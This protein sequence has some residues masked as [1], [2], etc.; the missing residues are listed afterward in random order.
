MQPSFEVINILTF[1]AA[2]FLLKKELEYFSKVLENP[3]KPLLV[4]MGG[5][6]VKDKIKIISNMLDRVNRMIITGGMAYT[7]LRVHKNIKIGNSIFDE[8]GAKLVPDLIKK[9]S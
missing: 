9:V 4:I 8:E 5:A 3:D 1:R 7:F 6:K 2:G